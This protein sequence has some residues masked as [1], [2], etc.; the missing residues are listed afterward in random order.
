[1]RKSGFMLDLYQ[2]RF[3]M[4]ILAMRIF[5]I[6][7]SFLTSYLISS[8]DSEFALNQDNINNPFFRDDSYIFIEE[9]RKDFGTNNLEKRGK[10]HWEWW[11]DYKMWLIQSMRV[12]RINMIH[13]LYPFL[14]VSDNQRRWMHFSIHLWWERI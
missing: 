12:L 14:R 11:W 9:V 13:L 6:S 3:V 7:V 2:P 1:M 8:I 4:K 10:S 5:P